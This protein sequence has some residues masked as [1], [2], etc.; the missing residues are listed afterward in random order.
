MLN[1]TLRFGNFLAPNMLPV[2][3]A[4][5]E[6]IGE[7]LGMNVE[8]DNGL[9]YESAHVDFE[10][11]FICGLAYIELVDCASRPIEAI[12]A[13]VLVG[14][15]YQGL[16]I[17]FSDVIVH[18]DS[19]FQSFEDLRGCS[20]SYNEPYSQSGYG[21]TRYWL[22]K[23][24]ETPSF[25]GNVIEAGWHERSIQ[26][27][28]DGEV[29][30]SAIDSQVLALILAQRPE[31]SSKIRTIATLGPS[32]IQPVTVSTHL[33]ESLRREIQQSF[34]DLS[35]SPAMR[36][37]LS[38]GLIDRFVAVEDENYNDLRIMRQRCADVGCLQ[39]Q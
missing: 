13:P 19:P 21:I 11:C 33:P 1:S 37:Q 24:G 36:A 32:T 5:A 17:Y 29:D 38:K 31:F 6:S 9:R 12:A 15:R 23:M 35:I 39:L 30:A 28:A 10:V 3:S 26:F 8:I 14:E 34:L 4:V 18:R 27:V 16:P 7:R 2:Y 20:W 22:S 25:F